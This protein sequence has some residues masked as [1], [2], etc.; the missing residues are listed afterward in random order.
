MIYNRKFLIYLINKKKENKMSINEFKIGN[1][2]L[3]LFPDIEKRKP[4][5]L[6]DNGK[7]LIESD[8]FKDDCYPDFLPKL[9]LYLYENRKSQFSKW[10]K[11][12]NIEHLFNYDGILSSINPNS[13][14]SKILEEHPL[15]VKIRYRWFDNDPNIITLTVE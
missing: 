5:H 11:K 3:K 8:E 14:F 1:E 6:I 10:L 9:I 13:E 7:Q 4:F 2:F 15:S 12:W